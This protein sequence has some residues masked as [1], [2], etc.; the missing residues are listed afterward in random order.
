[1][2]NVQSASRALVGQSRAAVRSAQWWLLL[3]A[4]W[5]VACSSKEPEAVDYGPRV[6]AI[7][8]LQSVEGACVASDEAAP[9][10]LSHLGC[11]RDFDV[12]ASIPANATIPGARSAKV[13]L[14]RADGDKL[15][16]QNSNQ[17]PIHWEFASKN[18]SGGAL[19]IVG[20]LADFNRTEYYSPDRRFILGAVTFYEGA[21]TWALEIAPYD[22]ADVSLIEKLMEAVK[23]HAYFGKDLLFHPT[24]SSLELVA[25]KLSASAPYLTND[26]LFSG[27]DYQPLNLGVTIGYLRFVQEANLGTDYVGFRDIVVL[28]RVPNDISVVSGIIT[29]EFQT[30]L[31]HVN[32]LS[33]NRGTPNMALRHATTNAELRNLEGKWVRLTVGAFEYKVEEVSFDEAEAYWQ[34]HKPTQVQ[35]PR[36]DLS[37]RE[38][39]NIESIV[40]VSGPLKAAISAAIP[41]FGGKAS[42][43]SVLTQIPGLPVAK[44]FGIP[45]WFYYQFMEQNGFFARVDEL[46]A[47]SAFRADPKLRDQ[48]LA[49]LRAAMLV[50]P[51]DAEFEGLLLAKL[52]ADYPGVR[53]RFRSSTNAEDLEG[54]TGAGLYTSV[55]G[56]PG[57]PKR[58]VL[59]AVRT[60]WASVWSFRA[61]EEREYRSIDH[62]AVGMALLVPHSFPDEEANGV[63]LTSNPFD[64]SGLEPSFYVNVQAGEASVVQ[65][66]PG[67]TTDQFVYHFYSPGQPI[68]FLAHSNLVKAGSTVLSAEQTY[69][70]GVALDQIH[71]YFAPAYAPPADML[72]YYGMDVEFKFDAPPGQV[73]VLA[74]KQARPHPGRGQ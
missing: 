5:S 74:V 18:L 14:D 40:D 23:A 73:P 70:L 71:Q 17:F 15:Y 32:V 26:T 1:M 49:E 63:A 35:V 47:D 67:T 46:L 45:V 57:D 65:P 36:L 4:I 42:H 13:V 37:V 56:Q 33:Q 31:S 9:S 19:P 69:E 66:D 27:I 58:P 61:F 24:S 39:A 48:K 44:A 43:Y 51:V 6:T 28:D 30:P 38:L 72:G 64:V 11:R 55:S 62:K 20:S 21:Q 52:Q 2:G 34:S 68:V 60:V 41:A 59:N 7:P 53:M 25:R 22:T 54:F 3:L 29:E 10:F 8:P 50:A 12:L 16:F